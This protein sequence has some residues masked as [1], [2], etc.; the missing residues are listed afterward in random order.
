[1]RLAINQVTMLMKAGF[2]AAMAFAL[3]AATPTPNVR[4]LIGRSVQAIQAD[5]SQTPNYSFVERDVESKKNAKPTIKT[6]RVLMI[7]GSP[8]NQLIAVDDQPL[9]PGDQAEEDRKLGVAIE[10]RPRE[11]ERERSR[12]LGKYQKE[13]RQD[14]AMLQGMVDAFDFQLAGEE[15]VNGHDCW[16]L[17]ANPKPGYRPANRETKVLLGMTGRL[18]IDKRE[19]QW[20]KVQAEVVKPVSF[21]GFFAKVGKGTRFLLEQEPVAN[22]VWLPKHFNMRVNASTLGFNEDSADD[23][24]YSDYQPASRAAAQASARSTR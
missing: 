20:V 24:T 12:R 17:Q 6:E 22:G 14:R 4:D 2:A 21:F 11:S 13:N 7:N 9:L 8:Y 23:E 18:W 3:P 10:K 16:V 5:W 1:M 19:N 15:M